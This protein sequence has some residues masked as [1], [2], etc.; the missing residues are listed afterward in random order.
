L[1]SGAFF[2][3]SLS[4]AEATDQGSR[5]G[6][7]AHTGL[8]MVALDPVELMDHDCAGRESIRVLVVQGVVWSVF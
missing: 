8:L 4:L 2:G 1:A 7:T 5:S 3:R 6:S